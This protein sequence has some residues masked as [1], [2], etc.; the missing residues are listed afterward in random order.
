MRI[1]AAECVESKS[2]ISVTLTGSA[3][4]DYSLVAGSFTFIR[5]VECKFEFFCLPPAIVNEFAN[6]MILFFR[7]FTISSS[8]LPSSLTHVALNSISPEV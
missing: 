7:I 6:Y 3:L 8:I 5:L 1:V 2:L 4:D